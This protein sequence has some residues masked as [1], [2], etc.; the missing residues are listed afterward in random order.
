MAFEACEPRSN[1]IYISQCI[2]KHKCKSFMVLVPPHLNSV[3]F[4]NYE[5]N[6]VH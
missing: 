5:P 4:F 2:S 6:F 1:S 3:A